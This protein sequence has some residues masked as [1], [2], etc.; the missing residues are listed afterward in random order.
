MVQNWVCNLWVVQ[1]KVVYLYAFLGVFLE[2]HIWLHGRSAWASLV[3]HTVHAPTYRVHSHAL[4][5]DQS[6]VYIAPW[7][8]QITLDGSCRNNTAILYAQI[9]AVDQG[10]VL[11]YDISTLHNNIESGLTTSSGT[12]MTVNGKLSLT[13]KLKYLYLDLHHTVLKSELNHTHDWGQMAHVHSEPYPWVTGGCAESFGRSVQWDQDHTVT[14]AL[15]DC[16]W[17][18]SSGL[19]PL[20][21]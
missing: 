8:M 6:A 20:H 9:S 17:I 11:P 1:V 2:Q 18:Q 4:A 10:E 7:D 13:L 5:P 21:G 14:T 12:L 19:S 15:E 3:V 16:E